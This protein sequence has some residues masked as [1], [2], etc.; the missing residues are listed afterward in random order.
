MKPIN[1]IFTGLVRNPELFVKSIEDL[2]KFR[3]EKMVDKIIFSSWL[4]EID[5]YEGL[6]KTLEGC[7]CYLIESEQPPRAPGNIWHQMKALYLGLQLIKDNSYCLKTRPDLFINS[8]FIR[9][10][11]SD[12]GYLNIHLQDDHD[13]IFEKKIGIPYF[14]ITKPFYMSDECFFG[15]TVDIKKL[16]NFDASYDVLYNIDCGITH[17]RRFIHPFVQKMP[18]LKHYLKYA[19][20][21][22][23]FTA[24]RFDILNYN[25][26]SSFYLRCLATYY[27]ILHTYFRVESDYVLEQFIFSHS[28]LRPTIFI[29][30]KVFRNN[31]SQE[32]TW[33]PEGG[34]IYAYNEAWLNNL[35]NRNMYMDDSL[36]ELYKYFEMPMEHYPNLKNEINSYRLFIE[37]YSKNK[38]IIGKEKKISLLRRL[39]KKFLEIEKNKL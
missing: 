15:K 2:A 33:N 5:K 23:H 13:Q 37:S 4:G 27:Q 29:D 16:V 21:S 26:K 11:I 31:F 14:E 39:R 8:K 20:Y 25:I 12:R 7:N 1:I 24:S 28:Y 18:L 22:G 38:D 34:H 32:K 3:Q 9:K 19:V 10:L 6:R 36:E 30:E 17:I 35:I